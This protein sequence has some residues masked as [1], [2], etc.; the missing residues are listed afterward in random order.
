MLEVVGQVGTG[1]HSGGD[2]Q[3][4]TWPRRAIVANPVELTFARPRRPTSRR[5]DA[6]PCTRPA[7]PASAGH[8]CRRR[9]E[10]ERRSDLNR[11]A[12]AAGRHAG[13]AERQV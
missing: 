1:L 10:E 6:I 13:V 7:Q 9:T 3:S 11:A 2:S 12:T 8:P 4:K 5:D